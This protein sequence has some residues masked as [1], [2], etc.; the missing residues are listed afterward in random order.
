MSRGIASIDGMTTVTGLVKR[1]PDACWRVL[2]DPTGYAGWIPK[3]RRARVLDSYR[4]GLPREI[5]FELDTDRAFSRVYRYDLATYEISWRP[6][7]DGATG[8]A[9]LEAVDGG[10]RL[11]YAL[12]GPAEYDLDKLI[13]SFQ[14]WMHAY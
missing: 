12:Q 13:A 5:R 14:S 3:L 9:R 2:V 4:T 1:S 8:F 11:T 6:R 7:G 10:T